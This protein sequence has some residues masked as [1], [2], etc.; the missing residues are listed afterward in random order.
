[1]TAAK[2]WYSAQE[3]A[4]LNLP[5]VPT[6]RIG[7]RKLIAREGWT[8]VRKRT[9]SGGGLEYHVSQ[10]PE[11][12]K[13]QLMCRPLRQAQERPDRDTL[14]AKWERLPASLKTTAEHR[15]EVINQVET[16][17]AQGM[18]KTAAVELVVGQARRE[19]ARS[20]AAPELSCST[21]YGWFA[22]IAGVS[23]ADRVAYLA[24][25]YSGRQVRQ[26]IPEDAWELYKGD[27]LREAKPTHA[28]CYQNLLRIADERGWNLP[29]LKTFQRR[30]EA[31]VSPPVQMLFRMG[32]EA[33]NYAFPH[34]D[35]DRSN[36]AVGQMW[37][38]D[39][40]TWD[41]EVLWDGVKVRVH[42][43]A[44]QDI[45][46]GKILAV[47]HDFTL[48]HHLVRL[49]IGDAL[50]E[51]GAPDVILMDNGRENAAAA[52]TGGQRR[53]RWGKTPEADP[54]G[55]LKT[56]G[57]QSVFATP[58]LGRAKPIERAFRNFAH[59]IAKRAEFEG[60]YTGHNPISRPENFGSKT[61][62]YAE[63]EAIVAREI[64]FYNARPGRTGQGMNGRS[65]DQAFAEGLERRPPKR[66]TEAQL[67][68]CMLASKPVKM[69]RL[70][71][72]VTVEGHRY[73]SAGL[74]DLPRQQVVVR[75]DPERM[76]LPAHIYSMDGK[77]LCEADRIGAGTFD[78]QSDAR[79]HRKALRD[80]AR[81]KRDEANAVRRLRAKDVAAQLASPAPPEP[82]PVASNVV[83]P[84]FRAA[85]TPAELG[86][87]AEANTHHRANLMA[88]IAAHRAGK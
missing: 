55:L 29:S 84:N 27:Y 35:R 56:L 17:I 72:A 88:G 50:R 42:S 85:R 24:P 22:R 9:E 78:S 59:D 37:N 6:T 10:L 7:V 31:E 79:A 62:H 58:Y 11:A 21:V 54:A 68:L 45:A 15:L 60:A 18:R 43:L 47:R 26:E 61:L 12:A 49:A 20:G 34:V 28:A 14:W 19:A 69:H 80:Y 25:E 63:F 83:T 81:A 23:L 3:L 70:T 51:Y 40:H 53:L 76:D 30:L 46:S 87:V 48:N 73:W 65:F 38:L 5:G 2:D 64:A 57:I 74:G 41:N 13:A 44:V 1:M 16:L 36:I 71:G 8:Q 67:R 52:I 82:I 86:Q 4:D 77:L 32:S 66:L 33:L 75:F 39:G